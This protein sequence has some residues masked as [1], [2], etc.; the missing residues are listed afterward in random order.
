LK[1]ILYDAPIRDLLIGIPHAA[2]NILKDAALAS[3]NLLEVIPDATVGN[4]NHNL[5]R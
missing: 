1:K 3:L 5:V 4:F 2:V